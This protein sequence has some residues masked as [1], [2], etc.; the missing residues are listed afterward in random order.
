MTYIDDTVPENIQSFSTKQYV[1]WD[2]LLFTVAHSVALRK[3]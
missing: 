3:K 1:V 2:T